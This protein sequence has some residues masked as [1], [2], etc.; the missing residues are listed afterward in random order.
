MVIRR[1]DAMYLA[2]FQL[3]YAACN[4]PLFFTGSRRYC[5][6]TL[7]LPTHSETGSPFVS[8]T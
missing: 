5:T 7:T 6:L 3:T 1:G 4:G 2:L 8:C